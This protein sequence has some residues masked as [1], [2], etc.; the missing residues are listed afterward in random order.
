MLVFLELVN[1]TCEER[2]STSEV[3]DGPQHRSDP[4][5]PAPLRELIAENIG[6]HRA[7]CHRGH[8]DHQHDPEQSAELPDMVAVVVP[9]M[10]TVPGLRY[11]VTSVG[12]MTRVCVITGLMF[13]AGLGVDPAVP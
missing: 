4:C 5:E 9:A 6:K 2:A 11:V 8:C 12:V 10:P 13:V 7:Q 3:N 1:C